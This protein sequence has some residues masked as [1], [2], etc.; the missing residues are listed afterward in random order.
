[1]NEQ[2]EVVHN[3]IHQLAA[4]RLDA[5]E[6]GDFIEKPEG[7]PSDEFIKNM[8]LDFGVRSLSVL[9]DEGIE[10]SPGQDVQVSMIEKPGREIVVMMATTYY[11]AFGPDRPKMQMC[12]HI[13]ANPDMI[14]RN[15]SIIHS[16][17]RKWVCQRCT[18]ELVAW[19]KSHAAEIEADKQCDVCLQEAGLF[20]PYIVPFG[21]TVVISL[22]VG[23]CCSELL[24]YP[25]V[26][27]TWT[28]TPRNAPCPCESG[29]KF[30]YCHGASGGGRWGQGKPS[31]N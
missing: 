26:D 29:R 5:E 8:S 10:F 6:R 25:K 2:T 17:G 1:M 31:S 21:G 19:E 20:M 22:H 18:P 28:K 30:K 23:D 3:R 7:W 27:A 13:E 12:P 24:T 16:S 9:G 14:M 4:W 11:A 15:R